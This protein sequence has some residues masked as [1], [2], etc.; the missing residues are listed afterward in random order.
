MGHRW[1]INQEKSFGERRKG[2]GSNLKLKWNGAETELVV[3][4]GEE[5]AR[6][7]LEDLVDSHPDDSCHHFNLAKLLWEGAGDSKE[8]AAEHFVKCAR[9]NP[10]N[11]A[12]F[13]YLGHYYSRFS[14]DPQR[15]L[16]CYQRA[17]SLHP[18]DSESG[19]AICDLLDHQGKE[20][21]EV[22]VCRDASAKSP[23]AFWAFRRLGYLLLHQNKWSEAVQSLQHAI[24]GYP[25]CADLWESY[26]RATELEESRVFAWVES[27]NVFLILNSFRKAIEQ[28]QHALE[29]S[30]QSISG[31]Y[32]LASGLLGLSK[33][34]LNLGSFRWAASL[35]EDASKIAKAGACL[36]RNFSCIW[37]L[38]GD[39]QI[40]YAKCFPWE[41][42]DLA[43][44]MVEA[45]AFKTSILTWKRCC[46]VA[47]IAA[48]NSYQRALHLAPWQANMYTDIAISLDLI[49]SLEENFN[50]NLSVWKL[51]E[52]MSLGSLLLESDN[53]EFWVVLGCICGQT[54]LKQHA[55]IRGLQL[56]ISLATAWAYLG[57]LYRI[58]DENILARQAFDRARSIDPSLALPWAGMSADIHARDPTSAEAYESCLRAA[59]I[60]PVAEFQIG[61]GKLAQPSGHLSS[62]KVF[63]AIRQAVQRA[64]HYPET[65]NLNGLISEAHF[66]FRSAAAYYRLAR[67]ATSTFTGSVPKSNLRDISI[68]LARS[69][70]LA[71][72]FLDAVKE[73]EDLHREGA[74]DAWGL[75]I[76]A[77][78]LWRV[79]KNDLALNI[80]R[81][82]ATSVSSMPQTSRAAFV[83]FVCKLLYH[84]SGK[85]SAIFSIQKMPKELFA[86]SKVSFV[87]SAIHA[88]DR[89]NQ[90]ESVVA[91]SRFSLAS[92]DEI[93]G[94]HLLIALGILIKNGSGSCLGVDDGAR[95]LRKALHI[96]SFRS[97]VECHGPCC[98][99]H[100]HPAASSS[101]SSFSASDNI[102]ADSATSYNYI[103]GPPTSTSTSAALRVTGTF[104]GYRKAQESG[105]LPPRSRPRPKRCPS[106]LLDRRSQPRPGP[107]MQHGCFGIALE[108]D[109]RSLNLEHKTSDEPSSA[110]SGLLLTYPL[111][112]VLQWPEGWVRPQATSHGERHH[113][114]GP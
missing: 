31:H 105:L 25:S 71:G 100:H 16:K 77:L 32:G 21:L 37:K 93:T 96:R 90:L 85:E 29:I 91:S 65:H 95:H 76:Y 64:P 53:P 81:N 72:S 113:R 30:P 22:A 58:E 45:E 61:L 74:L 9:L 2:G 94:M 67:H 52:K 101:S 63:G 102:P 28:F 4:G 38:H 83:S 13:R 33:E 82:L 106:L 80:A 114:T 10:G 70:C 75:Q 1:G 57:K 86:S 12:A 104:F 54:S 56:D 79:G 40:T 66:N 50:H 68:N 84:I 69:L 97:L 42:D 26:G 19:E 8:K 44:E 87:V 11:A 92:L 41:G 103:S 46:Y 34:C 55:Y 39:I 49:C 47:A 111:G 27:G 109:H 107:E 24:R 98:G 99:F 108:C 18:D 14:V 48:H 7:K 62:S 43:S 51:P 20:S 6:R 60:M 5:Q 73:C 78:S 112:P 110:A 3:G 15:A 23:R 36:A 59:Q 17:L 89:S 88:L 35:L